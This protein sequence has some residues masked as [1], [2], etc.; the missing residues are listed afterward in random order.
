M[1]DRK[2][3]G[4]QRKAMKTCTHDLKQLVEVQTKGKDK[5]RTHTKRN[6]E[7]EGLDGKNKNV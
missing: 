6:L 5:S 7:Q 2:A 1:F 4:K 3:Y